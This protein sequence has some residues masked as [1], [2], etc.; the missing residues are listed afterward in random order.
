MN[1]EVNKAVQAD[2]KIAASLTGMAKKKQGN[3]SRRDSPFI[4]VDMLVVED[5]YNIRGA[6]LSAEEYWE[7]E[8]VKAHVAGL[9]KSYREGA[10]VPP[11]VVKFDKENIKAI[12]RDG[13]HRYQA[14]KNLLAEGV[15]FERV[16]VVEHKGNETDQILLMLQSANSLELTA[17]DQAKGFHRLHSYGLEPQEIADRTNK[18]ITHVN[19]MLA[20]YDLPIETQRLIQ[21]KKL[22]YANA[23]AG[24]REANPKKAKRAT[25]PKKVILEF[26][27]VMTGFKNAP[28]DEAGNVSISIPSELFEKLLASL[29]EDPTKVDENQAE[30]AFPDD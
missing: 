1:A 24:A 28:V 11:I 19:N 13:H 15:E 22:S 21:Q 6:C 4:P 16:E 2:D 3:V 25:P 29:P 26:M 18:S 27:D 30:L 14:I 7:D 5:N 23:L 17:V 9:M 10:Y 12:I 8:K 20:V